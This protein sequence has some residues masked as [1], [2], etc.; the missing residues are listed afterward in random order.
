MKQI[1]RAG[2][3]DI[4]LLILT[5]LIWASAFAAIKFALED[6]GP[7]WTAASR[8]SI[9]FLA[10][11]PFAFVT[12]SSF[13]IS[14]QELCMTVVIALLITVI[15][16][17][18]ISWG[19]Q[20]IDSGIT[21]L[22]MGTTPFMAMIL[23]HFFTQDE[24]INRYKLMAVAV[25]MSGIML[26][27]GPDAINNL[28][29][30]SFVAQLAIIG[31]GFCYVSGGILIRK[32]D[33]KPIPFTTLALGIGAFALLILAIALEGIPQQLPGSKATLALL[34]LGFFPTG[35]AYILRF[36]LVR[37]VGVSTFAIGMNTIP[38]FGIIFGAFLLDETVEV[39]TMIAL[40]LVVSGLFIARLGSPKPDAKE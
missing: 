27:V 33:M 40:G 23:G 38:V 16:F 31:A 21:A 32:V 7:V 36:Y 5:A 6:M 28:G 25:G 20:H 39:K 30:T 26:I 3:I 11:L 12:K 35:L 1:T 22:L 10:L 17:I 18:L 8:V 13:R 34:W 15:P 9:G 14:R 19:L 37:K 24:S 2:G 4:S 29:S